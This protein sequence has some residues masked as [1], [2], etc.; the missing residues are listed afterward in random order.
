VT[1]YARIRIGSS[2][3]GRPVSFDLN[4][5]GGLVGSSGW[6]C[7]TLY[8]VGGPTAQVGHTFLEELRSAD[9]RDNITTAYPPGPYHAYM[10]ATTL[11]PKGS[12]SIQ[13]YFEAAV[14]AYRDRQH[15]G[16][17]GWANQTDPVVSP[18]FLER[19]PRPG[20]PAGPITVESISIRIRYDTLFPQ[21]PAPWI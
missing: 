18:N 9:P 1:A 14:A 17:S 6:L 16:A 7:M 2:S 8:A 21:P 20:L 10:S 19:F 15:P 12:R 5:S 3:S 4:P 13:L 11:A